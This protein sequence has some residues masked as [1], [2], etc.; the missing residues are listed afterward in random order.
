MQRILGS[1]ILTEN[2]LQTQ[3]VFNFTIVELDSDL[4]QSMVNCVSVTL[5]HSQLKYKCLPI[6]VCLLIH[7]DRGKNNKCLI[8]PN[9]E[10]LRDT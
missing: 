2:Y 9:L 1:V 10:S 4:L 3:I 6:G 8:D 7:S 5:L